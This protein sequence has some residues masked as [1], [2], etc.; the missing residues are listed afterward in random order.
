MSTPIDETQ[1]KK[2]QQT[3]RTRVTC[4]VKKIRKLI[5]DGASV[6]EIKSV[7]ESVKDYL[8]I[9]SE[10]DVIISDSIEEEKYKKQFESHLSYETAVSEIKNEIQRYNNSQTRTT[11][12]SSNRE[13]RGA[14]FFSKPIARGVRSKR[15]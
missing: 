6:S 10:L 14:I 11:L 4:T 8:K 9:L 15:R 5:C 1:A 3:F 2:R 13:R 12:K 7:F